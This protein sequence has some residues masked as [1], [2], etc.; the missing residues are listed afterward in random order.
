[1]NRTSELI[2]E[3]MRNPI[4][5][6]RMN[7]EDMTGMWFLYKKAI[8]INTINISE[9]R[10]Y[11]QKEGRSPWVQKNGALLNLVV[12]IQLCPR[13]RGDGFLVVNIERCTR[14]VSFTSVDFV[15][16]LCAIVCNRHYDL[17]CTLSLS[18][19]HTVPNMEEPEIITKRPTCKHLLNAKH[20]SSGMW[21]KH[22]GDTLPLS[23]V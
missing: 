23:Q 9:G 11:P 8:T 5:E 20:C 12:F 10:M 6:S 1:M 19:T 17:V 15:Y 3:G 14:I 2:N 7:L 21:M 13:E 4:K 22:R 16:L 18:Q